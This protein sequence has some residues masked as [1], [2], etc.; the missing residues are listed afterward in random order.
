MC[1]RVDPSQLLCLD[2]SNN[3]LF[4]LTDLADLVKKTPRLKALNLSHN[5]VRST[6][7]VF[8]V[9]MFLFCTL[10]FLFASLSNVLLC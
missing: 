8:D 9:G 7:I 10:L 3:K 4:R 6:P 1:L 2:L 5:E